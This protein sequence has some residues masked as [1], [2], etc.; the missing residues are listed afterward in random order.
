MPS[1]SV[2][3]FSC[4]RTAT[5]GTLV[6]QLLVRL[7]KQIW[8]VASV[9]VSVILLAVLYPKLIVYELSGIT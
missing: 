4:D 9:P 6:A 7:V 1:I 3:R 8:S 2:S 5:K